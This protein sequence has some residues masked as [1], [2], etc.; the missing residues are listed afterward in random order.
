MIVALIPARSG[1]KGVPNKNIRHLGGQPVLAWSIKACLK[2]KLIDR[3]LV[4][5]DSEH[6]ATIAKSFGAEVPFLRPPELSTDTSTDYDFVKHALDW[7][8]IDKYKADY[9]VHIRPTTPLRKVEVIDNAI[10][11]FI[12]AGTFSSLRSVHEMPESAYKTFELSPLG[13]LQR[14]GSSSTDI[15]SANKPRQIFPTTYCANGYVDV[16]S[17]EYILRTNCLHG[18]RA[19]PYITAHVDEID[20]E[21]DFRYLQWKLESNPAII[22]EIFS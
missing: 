9:I 4:S 8:S 14:V 3:V 16:L 11:E 13:C 1:S 17:A 6:Y 5:T 10:L 22:D 7:F 19:M 21:E 20:C 15:E 12:N 2:S 18:D